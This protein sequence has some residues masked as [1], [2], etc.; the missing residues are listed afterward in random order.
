MRFDVRMQ[1]LFCFARLPADAGKHRGRDSGRP[2]TKT[3]IVNPPAFMPWC[4][5]PGSSLAS[6]R[7]IGHRK[8]LQYAGV[9]RSRFEVGRSRLG[10]SAVTCLDIPAVIRR[11]LV[12]TVSLLFLRNCRGGV[13]WSS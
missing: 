10:Y 2:S 1:R 13:L 11:D 3:S 12:L 4:H 8:G 6:M 9:Q 5:L 7:R